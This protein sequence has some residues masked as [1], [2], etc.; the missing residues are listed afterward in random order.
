[1]YNRSAV[2]YDAIYRSQGKD[3]APEANKICELIERYKKTEGISLLDL[4]CGTG[5][6]IVYL[7]EKFIMEGL[8]NSEEML[9][10]A[11]KKFPNLRFYL[12]SMIDFDT[13]QFYDA[14][15]CLF[16]AIGYVETF[17]HL[18]QTLKTMVRHLKPGG[19]VIIEPWF[20]PGILDTSKV[21]AVFVDE[22]GVK[23]ARMNINRVEENISFLDFHY[24]VATAKGI[25]YFS[26]TPSLGIFTDDEYQQAFRNA[27]LEVFHDL[28]GLDGRGLYI[29]IK[30]RN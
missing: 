23:I 24:L 22:P 25:E 15:I 21:H 12:A 13:G 9:R 17:P 27:A 30:S 29:G 20:E 2:I 8:D 14:I 1:M 19:V 4:G 28:E 11:R 3:Y 6:H 5:T 16:S 10:I 7:Q 26:E 18:K